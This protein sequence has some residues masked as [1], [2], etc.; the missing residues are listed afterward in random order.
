M[1]I[2]KACVYRWTDMQADVLTGVINNTIVSWQVYKSFNKYIFFYLTSLL[3][4]RI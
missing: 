2:K 1:V 3:I 4:A